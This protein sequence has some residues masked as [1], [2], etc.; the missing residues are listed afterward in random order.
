MTKIRIT[1]T[2]LLGKIWQRNPF[3]AVLVR[4]IPFT[5][6]EFMNW[7][8]K[9]FKVEDTIRALV[10]SLQEGKSSEKR[11]GHTNRRAKTSGQGRRLQRWLDHNPR[12]TH[13][14]LGVY[15]DEEDR[16]KKVPTPSRRSLLYFP[17]VDDAPD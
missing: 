2:T 5:L 16:E 15:R 12:L 4:K 14:N 11:G 3:M 1:L 8:N 10:G 6:W 9:F 7:V 13:N 17:P